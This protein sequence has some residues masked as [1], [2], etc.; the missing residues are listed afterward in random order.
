MLMHNELSTAVQHRLPAVWILLNDSKY[1]MIDHGMR[2]SGF[3]PAETAIPTVS[4]AKK[5]ST[6][7][8]SRPWP[9]TAPLSSTSSS[10]LRSS[11]RWD[12]ESS[13]FGPKV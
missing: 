10:M 8:S 9:P 2:G 6:G 11:R 3:T 7:L 12:R 5:T 13:S 1:G 4:A